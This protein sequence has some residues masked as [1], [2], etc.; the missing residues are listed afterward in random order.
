MNQ[1]EAVAKAV[2]AFGAAAKGKLAD[3]A[4]TGQPEDQLRA[5]LEALFAA[6]AEALG[7]S[8]GMTVLVGE[9][10]LADL[11]TR[12]DYS[13]AVNKALTGF[14]EVKAPGKGADPRKFKDAHDKAQWDKLKALPNLIYTDGNAFSLWRDGAI[15]GGVV[16]LEGD[17]ESSGGKLA[18]PTTLLPLISEFLSWNPIPPKSASELAVTA[19]R[20]CRFL[21]DEV[22]EQM[23]R[24]SKPLRELAEDWRALL[25]PH[26]NDQEFADG[27]AQAVTFGLL[28]ARSL[29][30]PVVGDLDMVARKLG[31]SNTLIG[32]ALRLLTEQPETVL[33]ASLATMQ[34]VFEEID[35]KTIAKGDPEAWLYFYERFLDV[36]DRKL[37]KRTGSYYTPPQ[38]VQAMVRLCDEALRSPSRYG[39]PRGLAAPGVKIVDPAMGSGTFLLALLRHIAASVEAD[40]GQGVVPGEIAEA[41]KRLFGFEL[42][43]GAFAVAQLRLLAEM[44]D[45]GA[46][47]TPRLYVTDTLG[48]PYESFERAPG[49]YGVLARSRAEANEVKR[50]E[51]ITVVIGQ[52][53]L[54]G[55]GQGTR[56]LGGRARR[57]EEINPRRLAAAG[58][59]GRRRARQASA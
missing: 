49:V 30:Q 34:R 23:E 18:A 20:L 40:G 33:S 29:G 5:P 41:A 11:K 9:S 37:R 1:A 14:I 31:Q 22:I 43:F 3:Q 39:K 12:P 26:A 59:M 28:M 54:Q 38:V 8:P 35:W 10:S 21:R 55:K 27:Y 50:T 13:V 58:E 42:Q 25:F 17:I 44:I 19:A 4:V 47:E 16:H 15:V 52:S 24:G 48:D 6:L 46:A 7:Q 53:A 32:T 56:R 2:S 36:Y 51:P 45:F 57:D